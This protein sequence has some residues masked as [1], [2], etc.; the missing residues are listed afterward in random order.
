MNGSLWKCGIGVSLLALAAG[1]PGR[2]SAQ[3]HF[4]ADEGLELMLRYVVEDV[5]VPGM[6]LGVLE[7]DGTT[8]VVSYGTGGAGTRPLGPLSLFDLGS[9]TK[10]FTGTLLAEMVV[11]GEVALDDP[12]SRYLPDSVTVPSW[13]DREITLLDLATHTSGLPM[14]GRNPA[15]ADPRDP[16]TG[17][18]VE[19]M[20]AFLS[21]LQLDRE[22]GSA[23]AYSNLGFGLLG[24]AL[25]R[26]AGTTLS[27]ALRERVL[28]PL[29]M[30]MTAFVPV[31][32]AAGWMTVGHDP[33]DVVPIESDARRGAGGLYSNA[34]EML[35]YLEANVNPPEDVLG[36]AM[37]LAHE[38]RVATDEAG[39]DYGLGWQVRTI[40]DRSIVMHGGRHN[41]F[42]A[43]ICFD[44]LRRI[45][46]V[47]LVNSEGF[48]DGLACDLLFPS[49]PPPE[50]TAQVDTA[51]LRDYAGEYEIGPGR[52]FYVR[53]EPDGFLTYQPRGR[54]RARMY[55]K[56]DST[57][58]L[59]RGP[60][61]FTFR[62]DEGGEVTRMVMEV[63]A[64]EPSG[65]G[66]RQTAERE[67]D[68]L[69]P[70]RAVVSGD[71]WTSWRFPWG[72]ILVVLGGVAAVLLLMV[73]VNR[74]RRPS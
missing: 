2:V 74:A 60:W 17:F 13:G 6:V 32:E 12:V 61:S 40:A 44:P 57:F 24:H 4:P 51:V 16:F 23:Y 20:Y 36:Q 8:R 59:K 5:G 22:P 46:S 42:M 68:D 58:F 29:G 67:G 10:T 3:D 66:V 38:A 19:A 50:W 43:W 48:S 56:S 15:P 28:A 53:L 33:G 39:V 69:P 26:V 72:W 45:G 49:P 71:V 21:D 70:P 7:A 47:V 18:S 37:R 25:A 52:S 1:A 11:Q 41:G 30:E 27:E 62:R 35:L 64:R 54:A 65:A 31:G 63:D 34:R 9:V 55:A 73:L 14:W